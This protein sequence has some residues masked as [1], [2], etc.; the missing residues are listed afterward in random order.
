MPEN[1][2]WWYLHVAW[3]AALVAVALGRSVSFSASVSS[4]AT[5]AAAIARAFL[6]ELNL[7]GVASENSLSVHGIDGV[8][9][10][11]VVVKGLRIG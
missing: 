5:V 9:S 10:V 4:V 3:L 8:L 2:E 6:G 11:S 1:S 7:K